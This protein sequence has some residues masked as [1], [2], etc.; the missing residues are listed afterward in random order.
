MVQ[1]AFSQ[2][3]PFCCRSKFHA[4]YNMVL[5]AMKHHAVCVSQEIRKKEIILN[6]IYAKKPI[7]FISFNMQ[8][9]Y[10]CVTT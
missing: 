7:L 2:C 8:A 1:L 10:M 4:M 9:L 3:K 5:I 6:N